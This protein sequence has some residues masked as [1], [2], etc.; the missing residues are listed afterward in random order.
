[1]SMR[2]QMQKGFTLIELMIV[3]GIIGILAALAIPAYQDYI[4]RARVTE[5]LALASV[6]KITVLENAYN[7]SSSYGLGYVAPA[8][9]RGVSSVKIVGNG[10]IEITYGKIAGNGTLVLVPFTGAGATAEVLPKA[11]EIVDGAIRW[12]CKTKSSTLF[13]LGDTEATLAPKYAPP[14]CR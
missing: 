10:E 9:T 13:K 7:G 2:K 1:M 4:V 14:E 11:G 6:A 5:G 12:G 3:A 8:S